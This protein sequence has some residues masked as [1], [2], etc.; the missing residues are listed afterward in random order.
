MRQDA[1]TA[2]RALGE[3]GG[4]GGQREQE[5]TGEDGHAYADQGTCAQAGALW[6]CPGAHGHGERDPQNEHDED[7]QHDPELPRRRSMHSGIHFNA[8]PRHLSTQTMGAP[9]RRC[10]IGTDEV[11]YHCL[12][13]CP[14]R[15]QGWPRS[16]DERCIV[17]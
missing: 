10:S 6:T 17:A 8:P 2:M 4:S 5:Q 11:I 16:S 12:T 1:R 14:Q 13:A 7:E 3:R 9:I 15:E